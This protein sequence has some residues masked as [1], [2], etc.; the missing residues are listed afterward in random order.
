MIVLLTATTVASAALLEVDQLVN[1]VR[2]E[3]QT[4]PGVA[5]ALDNVDGGGPQTILLIGSDRRFSDRKV[6][7]AARS[8]TLMLVRLDP[9]KEATA[10]MSI[11]RD[12]KVDIP[13]YGSD[14]I[15]AAFSIGGPKLT[16]ETVRDLLG[17]E[18]NH[19]I[20]V[21]FGGFQRAVNRLGC[22][23]VDVDHR[24]YHSNVG[25]A[26]AAQYAEIDIKPGY[27]KLCGQKS[28]D[29]VRFR[30]ADSDFV[31]SA[32][33]QDFLRQAKGQFS[34]SSLLGDRQELVRI[35]ARYTRTDV[36]S[37]DAILQL[38]KLGFL[39]SKN[40]VREVRFPATDVAGGSDLGISPAALQTAVDEFQST[41]ATG[42]ASQTGDKSKKGRK[43]RSKQKK[44]LSGALPAGVVAAKGEGETQ[45]I[46]AAS[47]TPMPVY[48]PA[49]RLASGGYSSGEPDYPATRAYTIQDRA[50][51]RFSAYRIVLST[52]EAGQYYGVQGTTWTAPPILDTPSETMKMRGRNFELFY[53]GT[54]L[55]LV[56]LRT[57]KG[58]YWLSNT[59]SL[60]LTNPQMLAIAR[61]LTPLGS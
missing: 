20:E 52:G 6:K 29:L 54:R 40:P 26:P 47:K 25:L 11:P 39:S 33:Q 35:F 50:K 51:T 17:I 7:G 53:D 61:S 14:K 38:L 3:G 12:L 10:V 30:H 44:K 36:R 1:I 37:N 60:T 28:L 22:V 49:A 15:N 32:R 2:A 42:G 34:L 24:Y 46:T 48:F 57:S 21:N 8:D 59:L 45:A 55:R 18:I 9:N 43:A 4:I 13:G 5:N 41:T 56:A 31:R 19:I 23:Y 58:V 27:Q 16:L